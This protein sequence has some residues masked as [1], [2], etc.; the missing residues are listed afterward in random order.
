LQRAG[1]AV[2]TLHLVELLDASLNGES[3]DRPDRAQG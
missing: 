1:R 3:R 2:P